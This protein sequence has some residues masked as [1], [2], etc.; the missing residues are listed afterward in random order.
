MDVVVERVACPRRRGRGAAGGDAEQLARVHD[1]AYLRRIAAMAGRAVALD[2]DTYTSPESHEI[3]LLAAGAAVDAVE[4]VMA[5]RTTRRWRWCARP[6][7]TPSARRRWASAS[8]TTSPSPR[9]TPDRSAPARS[10]SWTTTCITATARSTSSRPIPTCCTS[11]RISSRTILARARQTR[12][13]AARAGVYGQR[14]ARS[15]RRRR[16]L[17]PR[18]R[19]SGL[20]VLRQF[21]PDLLL[22]SAG[23]DAHERDPSP[24]CD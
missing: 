24:A 12:S 8:T 3:A 7:I 11:R 23:F 2:P 17:P 14:A 4:R 9:R 10:R 5:R 15:R 16:G 21:E 20:P 18:V 13:A 22:V 19:R 1:A 6:G